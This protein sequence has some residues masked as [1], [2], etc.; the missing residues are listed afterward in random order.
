MTS[1]FTDSNVCD[2]VKMKSMNGKG[3]GYAGAAKKGDQLTSSDL[4]VRMDDA[5]GLAS[6][7][8]GT[9]HV[10]AFDITNWFLMKNCL[11]C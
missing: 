2:N 1:M 4:K 11:A 9:S 10:T 8:N 5:F 7:N 3:T 6:S